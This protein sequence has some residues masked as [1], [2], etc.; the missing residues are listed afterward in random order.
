MSEGLSGGNSDKFCQGCRSLAS[1]IKKHADR[2]Q[3]TSLLCRQID[4]LNEC[5]GQCSM[6]FGNGQCDGAGQCKSDKNSLAEGLKP[7][8]STSP[9]T[10]WGKATSGNLFGDKTELASSGKQEQITGQAGDGPSDVETTTSPEGREQAGRAYKERYEEYRKL[11]EEVLEGEPIPL[12][13]R[14]TIRNYFELI[15]PT[16]AEAGTE[17]EPA[18]E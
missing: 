4:K 10:N 3:M 11:S 5:K 15:R 14:Q 7:K 6:C 9:S 2:K 12:G 17:V 18:A 16:G 1:Q 8:K 13:H